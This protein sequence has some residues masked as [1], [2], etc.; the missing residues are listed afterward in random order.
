MKVTGSGILFKGTPFLNPGS[1]FIGVSDS[2]GAVSTNTTA[3]YSF[4]NT[5]MMVFFNNFY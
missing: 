5:E 4:E 1:M 3:D 2:E